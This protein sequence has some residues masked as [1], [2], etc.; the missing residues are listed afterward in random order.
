M[1]K[2]RIKVM[3]RDPD[4]QRF[5][6]QTF[7]DRIRSVVLPLISLHSKEQLPCYKK[8]PYSQILRTQI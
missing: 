4:K 7:N 2:T 6:P 3:W 8:V 1:T 5:I